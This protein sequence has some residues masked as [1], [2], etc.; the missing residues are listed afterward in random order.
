MVSGQFSGRKKRAG[1]EA[2]KKRWDDRCTL[3]VDRK[4]GSS[5]SAKPD[6]DTIDIA[7]N[8]G[9]V[10]KGEREKKRNFFWEGYRCTRKRQNRNEKKGK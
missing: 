6:I 8:Q 9:R 4:G 10:A 1:G 2:R 7:P 5:G 3:G